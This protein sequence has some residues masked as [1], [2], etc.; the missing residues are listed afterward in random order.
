M[1]SKN[2]F[3]SS[4]SCR[5]AS[6]MRKVRASSRALTSDDVTELSDSEFELSPGIEVLD[7]TSA[8]LL[9]SP[10]AAV[11]AHTTPTNA[12]EA[13]MLMRPTARVPRARGN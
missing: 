9:S 13:A 10:I 11:L 8:E 5:D 7:E 1:I 3:E 2:S 6:S 4:V 12:T